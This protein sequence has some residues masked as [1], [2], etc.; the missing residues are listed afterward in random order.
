MNT[1]SIISINPCL[2]P[3]GMSLTNNIISVDAKEVKDI[4]PL[5][6]TLKVLLGMTGNV[7]ESRRQWTFRVIIGSILM[8]F[9]LLFLHTEVFSASER[10]VPGIS[11]LMIAGGAFISCG[12]LTR[13]VSLA[14]G[15]ILLLA[16]S[17]IGVMYMT[18]F[19]LL[20]CVCA[21]VAA[22]ITGSGRY[23]LDTLIYNSI[24]RNH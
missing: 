19:S 13:L 9:G 15:I 23:S 12:L 8:V 10:I 1:Q 7:R 20:V 21:C 6:G 5:Q 18:G 14:L 17:H 24:L 3:S 2:E 16:F 4:N 11:F 22:T